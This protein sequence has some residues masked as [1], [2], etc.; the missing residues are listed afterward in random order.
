MTDFYSQDDIA[1]HGEMLANRVKKNLKHRRKLF[2][3]QDTNAFR[4]YD[5]DIPEVRAVVD[6]YDGELV[7]GEYVR[8][9]TKDIPWLETIAEILGEQLSLNP[10]QIHLKRRQTRP[11]VWEKRYSRLETSNSFR[12]VREQGLKFEVNLVDYL[13]TG[14]FLDHRPTRDLV[15]SQSEGK[16]VLNLFSYTGA[17]SVYGAAGG[18][19]L[20]TTVDLSANY[21][22]WAKRNFALNGLDTKSHEFLVT[23]VL[24]YLDDLQQD[25]QTWDII[26][27]DPPSFSTRKDKFE[28][29]VLRDHPD[30]IKK[31]LKLLS[32]EGKL[33]FSTNHQ[34]FVPQFQNINATVNEITEQSI[35]LD[36]KNRQI[37]RCFVFSHEEQS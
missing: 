5:W 6:W 36:F 24:Q 27:L 21:I 32:P 31:T 12:E 3:K 15:R 11:G 26:V 19:S 10:E 22:D 4:L 20:V 37:H 1:R 18:A 13:D 35:P 33:Y 25:D 16:K 2:R 34:R 7:I 8:E 23:D 9:Q 30:L 29:D 14:L 17:F 28:F